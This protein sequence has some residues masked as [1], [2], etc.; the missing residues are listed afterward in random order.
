MSDDEEFV[1]GLVAFANPQ[2]IEGP[3]GALAASHL[4]RWLVDYDVF[5]PLPEGM[6]VTTD[7]P[8]EARGFPD[9][10]AAMR[11]WRTDQ[12]LRPDGKPNR[13]LCAYTVAILTRAKAV[14]EGMIL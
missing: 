10:G 5:S 8:A 12:G 2:S 1:I 7:D 3:F 9:A 4:G 6:I 13:P 11:Y 14:E